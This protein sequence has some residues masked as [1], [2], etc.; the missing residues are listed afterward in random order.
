MKLVS[1][2]LN[3]AYLWLTASLPLDPSRSTATDMTQSEERRRILAGVS[4]DLLVYH[5]RRMY[6]LVEQREDPDW[7]IQNQEDYV[8]DPEDPDLEFRE[9]RWNQGKSGPSINKAYHG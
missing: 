9:M 1:Y 8:R 5:S 4:K 7:I 6:G 3:L 2:L